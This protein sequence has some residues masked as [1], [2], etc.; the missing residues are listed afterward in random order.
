M[1]KML[2]LFALIAVMAAFVSCGG[3]GDGGDDQYPENEET[4]AE[5]QAPEIVVEVF[6]DEQGKPEPISTYEELWS[7]PVRGVW[8]GNIWTSGYIGLYFYLPEG[9]EYAGDEELVELLGIDAVFMPGETDGSWETEH[10][11]FHD[12]WAVDLEAGS[13]VLVYIERMP[14][15]SFGAEE[16]VQY[17]VELFRQL[18]I[19]ANADAKPRQMGGYQWVGFEFYSDGTSHNVVH[20]VRAIDGFAVIIL[21][22]TIEDDCGVDDILQLFGYVGGAPEPSWEPLGSVLRV[23]LGEP[24]LPALEKPDA[25]HPLVG[26]WA[27]NV[28]NG[29]VYN[30]LADGTGTRGLT[31]ELEHFTWESYGSHLVIRLPLTDES[32][33]FVIDG[34]VLIIDSRQEPGLVWRYVRQ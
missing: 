2:T 3:N 9:W 10:A 20:F 29:F 1:G 30:F 28:Y 23:V 13:A 27:W 16:F 5:D 19:Y 12:M 17:S 33:T 8:N 14:F 4:Y 11:V 6:I 15:Y 21:V 26:K 34:D 25:S 32:W 24:R 7:G 31:G 22:Q 18:G